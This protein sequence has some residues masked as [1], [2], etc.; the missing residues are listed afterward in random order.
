MEE[1]TGEKYSRV[2]KSLSTLTTKFVEMLKA[3]KC[4]DLNEVS[5]LDCCDKLRCNFF[6]VFQATQALDVNKKRRI[7]DI[8]NVLEGV[9][10]IRKCGK[11][12]YS[13]TGRLSD[14][15]SADADSYLEKLKKEADDMEQHE[16]DLDT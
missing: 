1:T 6:A 2:Q 3:K 14:E 7:Y 8:T 13:W 4:L 15:D 5:W 11:N 16:K 9:F 10:L 12:Q